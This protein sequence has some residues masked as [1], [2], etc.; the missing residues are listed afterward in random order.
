MPTFEIKR[1]FHTEV[2]PGANHGHWSSKFTKSEKIKFQ[3]AQH[4][5]ATVMEATVMVV[6]V[7]I[8]SIEENRIAPILLI[9]SWQVSG[10]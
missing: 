8:M 4:I 10:H 3:S 2:P 9:C 1:Q 7:V 6:V 5:P